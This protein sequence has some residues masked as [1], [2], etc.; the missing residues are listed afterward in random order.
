MLLLAALLTFQQGQYLQDRLAAMPSYATA[1]Q[2]EDLYRA[3]VAHLEAA[4]PLWQHDDRLAGP[5]ARAREAARCWGQARRLQC[6]SL[7]LRERALILADLEAQ[8]GS[9]PRLPL[10]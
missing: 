6:L 1:D 4:A 5:L 9:P 8:Y 2:L 7:S 3:R 10:P